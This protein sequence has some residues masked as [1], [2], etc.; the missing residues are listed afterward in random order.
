V[1][2]KDL[3]LKGSY[4]TDRDNLLTEFYIPCLQEST[5]YN[6]AVG[7][8]SG[9]SLSVAAKG[10][11][12]FLRNGGRMLLVASPLLSAEDI[13][14]I[15][16]G[17]ANRRSAEERAI[18]G[19]LDHEYDRVVSARL[20]ILAWLIA[21]G[22]LDI[23]I[24]CVKGDPA[25][26]IY[27]E[28]LGL[29]SDGKDV[30]A[31]TGSPNESYNGLVSNFEAI[32]VFCSWKP[33]DVERAE[34][35]RLSFERLWNNST[36]NLTV[37]PFPEAA[38]QGLLR[39]RTTPMPRR[40]PE[41]EADLAVRD[42][43]GPSFPESIHLRSYQ[44]EAV[45][46]W[47]AAGCK[48]TLKMATGSGKTITAL[49][50]MQRLFEYKWLQATMVV[51]PYKHLVSQW[52]QEVKKFGVSPLLCYESIK[53]WA[54]DLQTA[55]FRLKGNSQPF[56]MAITTNATFRSAPF[57]QLLKHWP[58]RSMIIAD[59]AHNFG[60][61]TMLASLP[62]NI[63][64]RLALSATPERWFD[65]EGTKGI[66]DYFGPVVKPEFTLEDA[67][68]VG[69]LVPYVYRPVFVCLTDDEAERYFEISKKI[70]RIAGA[71][72][73]LE[74][75]SPQMSHLLFQ[76]ARLL[77]T[78]RNKIEALRAIMQNRLETTHSLFYCGDGTVESQASETVER[79][80]EAVCRMLGAD[81]GY[82]VE[83]YTAETPL[84]EREDLRGRFISG[85]L[86]GLVAIRCLDEGVDIPLIR[87]AF[88]LA[89]S[90]NPRQFIQRRGRVLRPHPTKQ[91]AEIFDFIV[92]PNPEDFSRHRS[93]RMLLKRE[94]DRYLEFA[95]LALNEGEA[96]GILIEFQSRY[97]ILSL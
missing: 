29:F 71:G 12:V 65:D 59:E 61:T 26:G 15:R 27:H 2:L 41:E 72:E 23:Q 89:S 28:K 81:L 5:T 37:Y 88:I 43:R 3:A 96:R 63:P 40:D 39:R 68:R 30:V 20:S 77:G 48:G 56:L 85:D 34:E 52:A 91:Q 8:F 24:A 64:W 18:L 7:F 84:E 69:A 25:V 14:A 90:A 55:L 76:R 31:F 95:G 53:T 57:Q 73:A 67:L 46:N 11:H 75:T 36:P 10:L 19:A 16:Q 51:V 93:E 1:G 21:L 35:K 42:C 38:R 80:V 4:R 92:L 33:E 47:W 78:A 62:E 79:H 83:I 82:R 70:A 22:R 97:G 13:E 45:T 17:Y 50:A 74:E 32:D 44:R 54:H 49:A 94:V 87:S 58:I 6:R 9:S 60:A 86:Q 66:F